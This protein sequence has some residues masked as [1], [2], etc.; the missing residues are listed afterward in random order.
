METKVV[1]F[2]DNEK[3]R[4]SLELMINGY[5]GFQVVGSFADYDNVVQKMNSVSADLVMMDIEIPPKNGIEAVLEIRKNNQHIP[6][7]MFT[8]FEEDEKIFSS[9]CAGAQG[10]LLKSASPADIMHAL[11]ELMNGG[12]PMTPSIA[13]KILKKFSEEIHVKTSKDDYNLTKRELEILKLLT[14]ENSYK[15]VADVL[16]ISY[17]TVRTHIRNIYSKLHVASMA[18]AVAKALNE[19][20]F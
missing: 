1:I 14:E 11:S 5:E 7:L 6:V 2:D 18:E 8:V 19:R 16:N 10:Y 13:R 15:S 4:T 9:I 20:L 17:E 12:A 3:I